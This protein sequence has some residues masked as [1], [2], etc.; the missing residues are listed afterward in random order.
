M[1]TISETQKSDIEDAANAGLLGNLTPAIAEKDIHVTDA[2]RAL[3]TIQLSHQVH[4]LNRRRGDALPAT[5]TVSA[6]LVFAGGTCLSK[7]YGLIERMSED[8]DIKVVLEAVP[9]GYALPKGVSNRKRLGDLHKEV[10]SRLSGLGFT[11]IETEDRNNPLTRDSRRYYCLALSYDAQ[12]QDVS[13]SLRPELKLELVCRTPKLPIEA[14]PIGYLL[15]KLIPGIPAPKFSMPCISV[16][17]TMAEKVL[18]LL[19]RCAWKWDGYQHSEFDTTL[20]RHIHDVWKII[21]T[22]PEAI[23]PAKNIFAGLVEKDI[24]EFRGKH[25]EFDAT[26]YDVM[27]RTLQTVKNHEELRRNFEE[28]LKPLLF[29]DTKPTFDQCA[30]SFT[31]VATALVDSVD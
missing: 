23:T 14:L 8:I 17:E 1:K 27:R 12:F 18:A 28:R 4:Q 20:V 31:A 3:S 22:H 26:P 6:H 15:D 25:P 2:L 5:Q 16:Y 21:E 10:E 11:Y 9:A 24:E 13:G 7:A 19:R 30:E 29:I